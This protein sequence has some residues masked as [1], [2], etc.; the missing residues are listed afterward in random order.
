[1]WLHTKERDLDNKAQI[2]RKPSRA[3]PHMSPVRP[4]TMCVRP[5]IVVCGRNFVGTG[6][7]SAPAHESCAPAQ[8]CVRPHSGRA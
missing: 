4:H 2:N 7:I 8:R 3:R 6:K 5:L 1:M